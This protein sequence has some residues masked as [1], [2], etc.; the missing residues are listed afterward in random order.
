MDAD[1]NADSRGRYE[2]PAEISVQISVN[3]RAILP[4]DICR[5]IA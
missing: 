4:R 1:F 2:E 5:A 3:L